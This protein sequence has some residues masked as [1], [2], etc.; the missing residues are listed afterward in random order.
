MPENSYCGKTKKKRV[1]CLRYTLN[2]QRSEKCQK[3]GECQKFCVS[4]L[5]NCAT[6]ASAIALTQKIY[7][8][9]EPMK[10]SL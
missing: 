2:E 7:T 6:T 5:T 4:P 1:Y 9:L 10:K 3:F 8:P